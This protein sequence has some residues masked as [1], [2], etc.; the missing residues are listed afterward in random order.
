MTILRRIKEKLQNE[1]HTISL[2]DLEIILSTVIGLYR[3]GSIL[4]YREVVLRYI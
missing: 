1:I 3:P 4:P 2:D